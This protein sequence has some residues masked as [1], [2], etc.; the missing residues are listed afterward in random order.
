MDSRAETLAGEQEVARSISPTPP[1][2]LNKERLKA[3]GSFDESPTD[4]EDNSIRNTS[5][6]AGDDEEGEYPDAT[7]M[8]FIVIALLLSIFLVSAQPF[9]VP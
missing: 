8:A 6:E 3:N 2:S 9:S 7:R 5:A 1:G 4:K